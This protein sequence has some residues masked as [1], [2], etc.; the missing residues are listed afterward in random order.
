MEHIRKYLTTRDR[1]P[2]HVPSVYRGHATWVGKA[3]NGIP[4]VHFADTTG[5]F[6]QPVNLLVQRHYATEAAIAVE[7]G[8]PMITFCEQT[9]DV[10]YAGDETT[11]IIEDSDQTFRE[12][13]QLIES[14]R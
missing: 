8:K 12:I 3:D 14:T 11:G 9:D 5:N 13:Q 7:V 2:R 6:R 10:C 1:D 4:L